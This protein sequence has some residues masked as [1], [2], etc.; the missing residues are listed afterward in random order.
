MSM[1]MQTDIPGM[2]G[3][4]TMRNALSAPIEQTLYATAMSSDTK[5]DAGVSASQVRKFSFRH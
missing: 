1:S 4:Q 3:R 2:T 5:K